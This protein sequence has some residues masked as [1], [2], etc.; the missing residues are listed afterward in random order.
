MTRNI[1][2]G[3]KKE[4]NAQVREKVRQKNVRD[5][6]LQYSQAVRPWLIELAEKYMR[7]KKVSRMIV[8]DLQLKF[9]NR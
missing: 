1:K 2:M 7:E 4:N 8:L 3:L 6:F 9:L 5:Y